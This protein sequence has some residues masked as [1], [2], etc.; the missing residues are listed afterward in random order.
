MS[1]S[2]KIILC[3]YKNLSEMF[4]VTK[5][6]AFEIATTNKNKDGDKKTQKGTDWQKVREELKWSAISNCHRNKK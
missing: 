2:K 4:V 5:V 1:V 3:A 6:I